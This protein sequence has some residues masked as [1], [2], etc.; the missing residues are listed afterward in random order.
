EV[1]AEAQV[2]ATFSGPPTRMRE[3]HG[4]I[5]RHELHVVKTLTVPDD[6]LDAARISDGVV[7]EGSD[8]NAPLG[9][10]VIVSDG[11]N[12]ISYTLH[13]LDERRFPVR[14]DHVREGP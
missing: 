3:L 6:K 9:V 5:Q 14:F 8:V 13:R 2:L 12:R 1:P 10:A 11:R 4:M 7:V